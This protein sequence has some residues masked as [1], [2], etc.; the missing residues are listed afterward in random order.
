MWAFTCIWKLILWAILSL[1]ISILQPLQCIILSSSLVHNIGFYS[2]QCACT[3]QFTRGDRATTAGGGWIAS[4]TLKKQKFMNM[5]SAAVSSA[6]PGQLMDDNDCCVAW[7]L[8]A[9]R[10]DGHNNMYLVDKLF[11]ARK[12]NRLVDAGGGRNVS[13]NRTKQ[14]YIIHRLLAMW[15]ALQYVDLNLKRTGG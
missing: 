7:G 9:R 8:P 3:R 12:R 14:E 10:L 11:I 13:P 5:N 15:W 6:N 2:Y 1:G 4:L